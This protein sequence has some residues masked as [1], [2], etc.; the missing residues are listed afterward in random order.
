MQ[1]SILGDVV[2]HY[3]KYQISTF[4]QPLLTQNNTYGSL[5]DFAVYREH[6]GG[7]FRGMDAWGAFATETGYT[8]GYYTGNY[9]NEYSTTLY[10]YMSTP[11]PTIIT[12]YSL[13][14]PT[15][16]S[17]MHGGSVSK[18]TFSASNDQQNWIKLNSTGGLSQDTQLSFSFNNSN[19][20]RYYRFTYKT[21]GSGRRDYSAVSSFRLIGNEKTVI[22]GTEDDYDFYTDRIEGKHIKLNDK[23]YAVKG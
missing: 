13:Y 5:T 10:L 9:G 17:A 6:S 2:R 15:V 14:I 16:D 20:Y 1:C 18:T 8:S 4:N 22:A 7:D 23:Y 3:F 21:V 12:G 19:T 11:K